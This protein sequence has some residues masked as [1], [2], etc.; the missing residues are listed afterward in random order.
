MPW[1]NQNSSFTEVCK[2]GFEFNNETQ[3]CDP[4]K[5]GFYKD[6]KGSNITCKRCPANYTTRATG[7]TSEEDCKLGEDNGK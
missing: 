1:Y 3:R 2:K 5:L 6:L 4:C 7:K